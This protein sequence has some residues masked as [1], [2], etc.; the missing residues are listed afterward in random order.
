MLVLSYLG[1][2]ALIPFF[3]E[4]DDQEVQWHA[5]HGLVLFAAE[6]AILLLASILFGMLAFLD[7]GCTGC[8]FHGLFALVVIVLH[9]ACIVK[10][11][12]GERL[13]IP[14][15]SPLADRF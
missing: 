4:K 12:N 14:G 6:I 15:I 13:T 9:I 2:L 8:I 1:I 3:I 5:K 11:V 10:A 7:F